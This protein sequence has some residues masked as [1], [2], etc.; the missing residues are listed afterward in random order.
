MRPYVRWV[1]DIFTEEECSC[2]ISECVPSLNKG[3]FERPEN[4]LALSK[5]LPWLKRNSNVAWISQGSNLDSL[6]QRAV[7]ILLAEVKECFYIPCKTVEEVQFTEYKLF[8]YYCYHIDTTGREEEAGSKRLV[9]ATI[10][11]SDPSDY[12]GGGLKIDLG[13]KIFKAP[14]RQGTITIF[15]SGLRHK[16]TPILKGTRYSLVLWVH[17]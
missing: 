8:N 7:D 14:K 5:F 4:P 1:D 3:V 15:P 12:W 10:Q 17:F 13:S 9:S 11:L 16:V 2:I 6:M